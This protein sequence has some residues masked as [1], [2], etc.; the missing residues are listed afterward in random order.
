MLL[1]VETS[2]K[3]FLS[4]QLHFFRELDLLK[5][6]TMNRKQ[7]CKTVLY[8]LFKKVA[9]LFLNLKEKQMNIFKNK[10]F[11]EKFKSEF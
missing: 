1:S 3:A 6:V 11:Y 10:F 5:D 8:P 4:A 2:E 9:R 7:Q